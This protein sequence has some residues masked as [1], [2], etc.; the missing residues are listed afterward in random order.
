VTTAADPKFAIPRSAG[1]HRPVRNI[2]PGWW[3]NLEAL[4][5]APAGT[6]PSEWAQV[7][8]LIDYTSGWRAIVFTRDTDDGDGNMVRAHKTDDAVTLTERE[9]KRLGLVAA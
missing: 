5:D 7:K 4:P 6:P 2:K 3:V 8:M 9:A 1:A